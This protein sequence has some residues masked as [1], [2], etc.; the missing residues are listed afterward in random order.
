MERSPLSLASE[1]SPDSK[2]VYL[3]NATPLHKRSCFSGTSQALCQNCMISSRDASTQ[4]SFIQERHKQ[5][6]EKVQPNLW[7]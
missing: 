7:K 6:P 2:Q 1:D 4:G 5:L 3:P